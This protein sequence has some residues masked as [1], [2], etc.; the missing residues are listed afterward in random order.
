MGEEAMT[1][2]SVWLTDTNGA[3]VEDDRSIERFAALLDALPGSDEEH[4]AVSVTDSDEWNLEFTGR[5]VLFENVGAEGQEVGSLT[6]A[7]RSHA[8]AIASEFLVG[9]FDALRARPWE[10]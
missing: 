10:A 8:L 3:T 9:D 7:D 6:L 4:T 1:E 2:R 5:S